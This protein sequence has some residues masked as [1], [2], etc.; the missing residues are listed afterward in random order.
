MKKL[1]YIAILLIILFEVANVYFIMPFPG[2]QKMNT[3]ELAHFLSS[4]KL[5]IRL[6]LY[7]MLAVGLFPA[8]RSRWWLSTLCILL[9]GF[10]SWVFNFKMTA[11]SIF[12]VMAKKEFAPAQTSKVDTNR[13]VVAV[14]I[15]GDARAYPIQ[16]IAYHHRVFDTVGGKVIMVTYCS[17]CRTG[18][19]FE[20]VVNGV[21]EQFKLVGMDHFNAM[22]EDKTTHSWW[23]QENGVAVAGKLKGSQLNEVPCVQMSL[24]DWFRLHP[25]GIVLQPDP[26]FKARYDRLTDYDNGRR[27]SSLEG[28][29]FGS[30]KDKSWVIGVADGKMRRAYD[31]N[32]LKTKN[33]VSDT[34]NGKKIILWLD[35]KH[36]SFF[37]YYLPSN[38]QSAAGMKVN[39]DNSIQEAEDYI[40]YAN[41]M[42]G[43][44]HSGKTE[45]LKPVTAY[46]EFWH[47]WRTFNPQTSKYGVK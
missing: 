14:E 30:W 9:A 29:D 15:N 38:I 1:F 16:Y 10:V 25:K 5:V 45:Q 22:F 35:Q 3:V 33:Y 19:V 46:Q 18:R 47:S 41:G 44:R 37:A 32:S 12:K 4:W 43:W 6:L 13:L 2:S 36:Q 26:A 28:T 21:Q 31:W 39:A 24:A 11:S 40:I 8:M 17:V 27:K 23:R 42:L 7:T 20:P 34:F